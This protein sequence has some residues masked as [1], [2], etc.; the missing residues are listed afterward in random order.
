VFLFCD[1]L[2]F[3][4]IKVVFAKCYF[5]FD[6]KLASINIVEDKANVNLATIN[7]VGGKAKAKASNINILFEDNRVTFIKVRLVSNNIA[8]DSKGC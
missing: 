8:K 6:I 5:I 2:Y 4:N 1:A 7:I 3:F